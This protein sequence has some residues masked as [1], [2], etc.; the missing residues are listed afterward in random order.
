MAVLEE[1]ILGLEPVAKLTK[2]IKEAALLLQPREVRYLV[3]IFYQIQDY[4]CQAGNQTY[5]LAQLG[6]PNALVRWIFDQQYSIEKR[7]KAVLKEWSDRQP[8]CRWAKSI[9]GIGDIIASGLAAHIDVTKAQTA[10]DVWRYAGLDPS[11]RWLGSEEAEEIVQRVLGRTTGPVTDTDIIAVSMAAGRRY[12][13][14]L[15]MWPKDKEGK[16]KPK[17]A[18]SLISALAKRPW[19]HRFKV[20]CWKI[21]E[22]FVKMKNRPNDIYGKVYE[23]RKQYEMEKNERGEYAEQAAVA[24]RTRK[25]RKDTVAY[26]YY[27]KDLLPPGHINARAKRYAVKLFLSHYHYVAYRLHYGKEPP[28]PYV[29]EHLG[30]VDIMRVPN[31]HVVGLDP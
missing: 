3:D 26:Q 11:I 29:V 25:I 7:I 30:H 16:M 14:V 5:A 10:G 2:D 22:S 28:K 15:A 9:C 23:I 6:E 13:S 31:L 17:T 12:E 18:E 20:L 24:L 19:N 21:G 27:K 8:I 1:E 4:R